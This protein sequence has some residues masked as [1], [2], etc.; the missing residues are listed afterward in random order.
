MSNQIIFAVLQEVLFILLLFLGAYL[1]APLFYRAYK[2]QAIWSKNGPKYG[3]M[4]MRIYKIMGVDP[5]ESMTCKKYIT[6][7]L[8][9]SLVSFVGLYLILFFQNFFYFNTEGYGGMSWHLAFNTTASFVSNTNWQSY[10]GETTL[11]YFSQMMG[12]TVQKLRFWSSW[13]FCIVRFD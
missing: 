2:G 10:S 3:K 9:F 11:S 7:M 4:E 6:H 1:L 13:Y 5:D 12:L 8:L